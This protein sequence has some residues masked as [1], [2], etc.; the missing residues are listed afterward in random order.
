MRSNRVY[1]YIHEDA[2]YQTSFIEINESRKRQ[3]ITIKR[4]TTNS[5]EI[6]KMKET[7]DVGFSQK[8][9]T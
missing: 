8:S 6:L 9:S 5:K 1:V 7:Y 3:D 2:L 4:L